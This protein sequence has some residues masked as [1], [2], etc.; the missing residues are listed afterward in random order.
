MDDIFLEHTT[1]WQLM[2]LYNSEIQFS[3]TSL[4]LEYGDKLRDLDIVLNNGI[5]NSSFKLT[6]SELRWILNY[7]NNILILDSKVQRTT[8]DLIK[9]FFKIKM[10]NI[11]KLVVHI[12]INDAIPRIINLEKRNF[13]SSLPPIIKSNLILLLHLFRPAL[14][15]YNYDRRLDST[16]VNLD[17]FRENLIS[18]REKC[19]SEDIDLFLINIAP[20]ND[21]LLSRSIGAAENIE[22]YNRL[23][24]TIFTGNQIIDIHSHFKENVDEYILHDGHHLTKKGSKFLSKEIF[25]TINH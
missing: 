11:D 23:I 1:F 25:N 19:S 18:L 5:A 15:K 13:I 2:S 24:K 17:N 6:S 16:W 7:K 3:E 9:D 21:Y 12:G 10:M 4:S 22:D 8:N 14:L 20:P